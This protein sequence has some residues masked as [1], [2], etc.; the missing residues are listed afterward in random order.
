MLSRRRPCATRIPSQ[1]FRARSR[2]FGFRQCVRHYR[3]WI[4]V[5]REN[6]LRSYRCHTNPEKHTPCR[7]GA[8]S[9]SRWQTGPAGNRSSF[10]RRHGVLYCDMS[11]RERETGS[12][13]PGGKVFVYSACQGKYYGGRP[14][15]TNHAGREQTISQKVNR[16]WATSP[17]SPCKSRH[18]RSN[19][20]TIAPTRR[21]NRPSPT[22]RPSPRKSRVTHHPAA[23]SNR[24]AVAR[25]YDFGLKARR[26]VPSQPRK[27]SHWRSKGDHRG[28]TGGKARVLWPSR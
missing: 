3:Q 21:K 18:R 6:V 11:P 10:W 13:K 24:M 20:R 7:I 28:K 14:S 16:L 2:Y 12:P 4:T 1:Y 5:R 27:R 15:E 23:T 19:P 17:R 8:G 22:N 26:I 9:V 25:G